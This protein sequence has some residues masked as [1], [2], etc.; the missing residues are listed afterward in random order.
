M[1]EYCHDEK[2][3]KKCHI[4]LCVLTYFFLNHACSDPDRLVSFFFLF[5]DV[6][7][8]RPDRLLA[9]LILL[10]PGGHAAG[11]RGLGGRP[12]RMIG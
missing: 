12:G 9:G 8:G 7:R 3:K 11:A 10:R 6:A 5:C 1:G 4:H 2:L